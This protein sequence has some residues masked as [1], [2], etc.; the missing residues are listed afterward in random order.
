MKI[1]TKQLKPFKAE[2]KNIKKYIKDISAYKDKESIFRLRT[3]KKIQTQLKNIVEKKNIYPSQYK[4]LEL[5]SYQLNTPKVKNITI[6]NMRQDDLRID[7]DKYTRLFDKYLPLL[8]GEGKFNKGLLFAMVDMGLLPEDYN[9]I[10]IEQLEYLED[11][12]GVWDLSWEEVHDIITKIYN[13]DI[14]ALF[15][16]PDEKKAQKDIPLSLNEDYFD[17]SVSQMIQQI[18]LDYARPDFWG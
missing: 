18:R 11:L 14:S 9:Q 4:K 12:L 3:A 5:L 1:K 16:N 15:Y 17:M 7:A 10:T 8:K 6:E 13:K 2:L